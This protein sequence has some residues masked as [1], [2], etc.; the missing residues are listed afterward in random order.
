MV[1]IV[2][3]RE[4][5]TP[6]RGTDGSAGIDFYIPEDFKAQYV[7]PGEGIIIPSGIKA[8]IPKG[9]VLIAFNKSGVSTKKV[10]IVGAE[11][12]DGD[13][14]GEI[15]LHVINTGKSEQLL[16]PGDKLIQFILL[17]YGT[18]SI[19]D[20]TGSGENI[21]EDLITERGEGRFGSTGSK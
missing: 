3:I 14:T 7:Y 18:H 19:L 1:K 15:S 9:Y 16:S 20:C 21:F 12:V 17:E 11:V 10:L 6:N 8:R 4:V 2:K 13:Y 5:K